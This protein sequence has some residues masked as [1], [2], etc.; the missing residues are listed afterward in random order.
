MILQPSFVKYIPEDLLKNKMY[1]SL[2]NEIIAH[3]CP[4]G[5]GEKIFIP[6]TPIGWKMTFDGEG[7][8]ISP[9][10]GNWQLA[11]K[12]HYWIENN[13]V[14]WS[15]NWSDKQIKFVRHREKIE[16]K[17]FYQKRKRSNLWTRCLKLFNF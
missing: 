8:S 14:I 17:A 6:L 12:S 1:I 9:S 10:I 2:E 4:C 3:K 11:C 7:I 5:C 13:K 16:Q 15:G